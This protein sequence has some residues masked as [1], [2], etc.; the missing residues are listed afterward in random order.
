MVAI[1]ND[2]QL[3]VLLQVIEAG[4]K[5]DEKYSSDQTNLHENPQPKKKI[6]HI[7][8][9]KITATS[10]TMKAF[11]QPDITLNLITQAIITFVFAPC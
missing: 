5:T 11:L 2:A 9:S 3:N 6:L 7:S 4:S 8:T 10:I 1:H